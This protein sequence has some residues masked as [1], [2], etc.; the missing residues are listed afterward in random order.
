MIIAENVTHLMCHHILPIRFEGE[1][2]LP[3][4]RTPP[5]RIQMDLS[6]I[7]FGTGQM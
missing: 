7:E 1:L 3:R 5:R 6:S 2:T 4:T